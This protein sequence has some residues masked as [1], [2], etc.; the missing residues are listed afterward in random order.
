MELYLQLYA[1]IN[2]FCVGVL[3]LLTIMNSKFPTSRNHH[4]N[5]LLTTVFITAMIFFAF[6]FAFAFIDGKTYLPVALNCFVN[7]G[8]FIMSGVAAI[9]WLN[10]S[11]NKLDTGFFA[12]KGVRIAFLIPIVALC[13]LSVLPYFVHDGVFYIDA[14]NTY[15]RGTFYFIQPIITFGYIVIACIRCFLSG[16]REKSVHNRSRDMTLAAFGFAPLLLGV[17]QIILPGTPLLCVGITISLVYVYI[18]LQVE[19]S[20]EQ[21]AVIDGLTSDYESVMLVSLTTEKVTDFRMNSISVEV[22]DKYGSNRRYS[23]RVKDFAKEMLTKEDYQH[24]ID[25]MSINHIMRE[26]SKRPEFLTNIHI[27]TEDGSSLY[28]IKVVRSADYRDTLNVIIGLRNIDEET[29]QEI[30]QRELLEEA[31]NRAES[32]SAA[33]STF[34]FNMSHDIRT[35]MNAIIGFTGMAQRHIDEKELVEDYLGKIEVSSIH[36]LKLINDVLDMARIESGKVE[37]VPVPASIHGCGNAIIAMTDGLAKEHDV[38]LSVNYKDIVDEYIWG[39]ILHLDQIMVNIVSNAIKYTDAGGKVDVTVRQKKYNKAG[40]AAYEVRV[41]DNGRGMS[42]DFLKHIF[43]SFER[44]R[45]STISG[46]QGTGLGMSIVKRLVDMMDGS[47]DIISEVGV[48]TTVILNFVFKVREESDGEEVHDFS[49]SPLVVDL[50]DRRVLVVEDNELNQEIVKSILEDEGIIVDIVS[51]G[52]QAVD[53]IKHSQPGDY[54]FV[55][56]DIQMP[57]LDGYEATRLIRA[58]DCE[59]L[60]KIP[61]IAMTANAF[62][63]DKKKALSV[64]MNAHL[65][66]PINIGKLMNTITSFLKK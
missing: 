42:P 64:G 36:L 57:N 37:I 50:R 30:R 44:E 52:L 5:E 18:K 35:P 14:N 22:Q 45:S 46:V 17:L 40:E 26:L 28:Q 66:K 23:Q 47:I 38:K 32:A 3:M 61:I 10:Y 16:L 59:P 49:T 31:R 63:E 33:K 9:A 53:V 12:S 65:A 39:D 51:D 41:V 11:E 15:H 1:I 4:R 19:T 34:L 25:S 55:L 21:R 62:E 56:M 8:Y 7:A 24:Y 29:R 6:D 27:K 13:I 48:G 43:D 54:D 20:L 2:I 58:L 60:A